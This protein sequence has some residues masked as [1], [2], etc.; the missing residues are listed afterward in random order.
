VAEFVAT[1]VG[2]RPNGFA[3]VA[4]AGV[5]A[6]GWPL[7]VADRTFDVT[8]GDPAEVGAAAD[9]VAAELA[10]TGLVVAGDGF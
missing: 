8:F 2:G 7:T 9:D 10:G 1:G 4:I 6:G 3:T 5:E